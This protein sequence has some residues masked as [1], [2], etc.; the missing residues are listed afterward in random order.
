MKFDTR[1]NRDQFFHK[2]KTLKDIK[3]AEFGYNI[4]SNEKG[5]I[6]IKESL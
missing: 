3:I 5:K 4:S 6:F 1:T 2:V